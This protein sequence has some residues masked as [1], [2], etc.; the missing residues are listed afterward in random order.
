M[1][2]KDI[3]KERNNEYAYH[4]DID[5]TIELFYQ[6]RNI[7]V[8]F[9]SI[10]SLIYTAM[11]L[12]KDDH[13]LN[14]K[15]GLVAAVGVLVV[16]GV[17]LFKD[18]PFIRP[19]PAFWRVVMALSIAYQMCLVVILFQSKDNARTIFKFIDPTLGVKL[20]E[21]NYGDTC[22]LSVVNIY[23]QLDRFVLAHT[24]GWIA[25]AV[26]LRDYWLC[27]LISVLFEFMEYSLEHQ[28]PNF[29]ECWWYE[30]IN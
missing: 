25:K 8:L 23:N 14:F 17:L 27:W 4:D 10:L 26:I 28:L 13:L 9:L 2:T 7:T 11:Y 15:L 19:H 6:P 1:G 12:C 16:T 18:G 22:E 29:G 30:T 21:K 20:P 24:I 5:P 3:K